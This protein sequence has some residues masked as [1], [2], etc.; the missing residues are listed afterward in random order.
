M[1]NLTVAKSHTGNFYRN[2]TG[3]LYTITV[4]NIG[5]AA[6]DGTTVT[7]ADTLWANITATAISGTGWTCV[8]GTRTC[9]RSDVL[10]AGASYPVITLTVNVGAAANTGT[11]TVT[12]I[13]GGDAT[14]NTAT[15][16]TTVSITASDLTVTKTHAGNFTQ[17]QN[18]AQYTITPRNIGTANAT[19]NITITDTLP[20]G[21][22]YVS[23]TG[24]NWN[25]TAVAQVVTCT[26]TSDVNAGAFGNPITLTVNVSAN[27]TTPLVNVAS[28]SGGNQTYTSN[29]TASDSTI[30]NQLPDLTVTKTHSG[31]FQQGDTGQQYTIT[32]SNIGPG[33]KLAGNTVTV[34]DTLPSDLTATA[35]SGTNWTCVLGTLTC[36]RTD[37]L[38]AG[39]SYPYITLTVDVAGDAEPSL[40]NIASVSL[41]GQS[42]MVTTNNSAYDTVTIFYI[43]TRVTLFD[44]RAYEK[45]GEVI[46]K[47]ETASELDTLGFNLLR[48]D[49]VTGKYEQVNSDLLPAMHR[50]HRG[51]KYT[52]KDTGASPGKTYTYKL[53]EVEIFGRQLTY[54]PFTV[55]VEKNT[56]L[57]KQNTMA[58]GTVLSL[59]SDYTREERD[60]PQLNK[61]LM[62]GKTARKPGKGWE[63]ARGE[64]IKITVTDNGIY[65]IAAQ[66]ISSLMGIS[67]EKVSSLIGRG[68]LSLSNKGKQVAYLP[69]D[70]NAGLY[71]YGTRID[72]LYTKENIYWLDKG[73]G[74]F[75]TVREHAGPEP[76]SVETSFTE[77]MHIEEDAV[78][79]ETLF[80][81]PDADYWFWDQIFASKSYTD[82]PRTFTFQAPGLAIPQTT[83]TLRANLFGA[84]DAGVANDHHVVISLNG[85]SAESWWS[86]LTPHTFT[87][88]FSLNPGENTLTVQGKADKG[89]SSSFVLIDSFDVTYQRLYEA[90]GD[91]LFFS[92]DGNQPITVGGF[93]SPDIM[94]F[95]LT[96]PLRPKLDA[97]TS[98]SA[99][100]GPYTVSLNPVSAKT[101]YLA[102]AED[103][104][105]A[106]PVKAAASSSLSLK[107]NAADYIVIAPAELVST[108]QGL[109]DYRSSQGMKT[110][111]VNLEDIMNE[112]N[113]GI[114]SPEAIRSFLSVAY[115]KWKKAP[116]YV[117]LAG[118]GSMDYKDNLKFGGSLIPSKMVPTDFGLAMSDNYLA[119]VNG[120]HLPEIAIGRL[121]VVNPGELQ[122]V[123]DKIKTYERNLR[124]TTAVLMAD[125]PD[126]GGDFI[127]DSEAVAG[128]FTSA[129][130]VN[131]IYL[132]DPDMAD[133]KRVDLISAINQ[134]AAFFNYVGHAGPDQLSNWGLLSYYPY[135]EYDP[136]ADD[137]SLLTNSKVLPVM[138]A[139]TC[140]IAN[141]SDPYQ[142]VL[143]EALLLKPDGGMAAT[144]SATGLSDDAQ[145]NILNREFYKSVFSVKKAVLGDAVL[146]AL[147]VY[148]KQ[149]TMPFMMD[150]YCI[151][152]DPALRIR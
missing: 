91:R 30:V 65:Y 102:V 88:T 67:L 49:S 106:A 125:T 33:A 133:A 116:R 68:N 118:D 39:S 130:T 120:D 66:N 135:P 111:V 14:L 7:V 80:D 132:T 70:N 104:I 122:T 152:G 147:S 47:W 139:M 6:T 144:W 8:L 110:M 134:G 73:K 137:L 9:T 151:L 13:G 93:S 89:V 22:T 69:A 85:Q 12:V 141:F 18:G 20:T 131:K 55:S 148:N 53:I 123:I 100:S 26:T 76:S 117:V 136:P 96:N 61:V 59:A 87:T 128:L 143:G 40:T 11:N 45:N 52:F 145:A 3:A 38:S 97:A 24:T 124:S 103:G 63:V 43:P 56:V 86:G 138:T 79:W 84:S 34:T 29:D 21:L 10:A 60:H 83:A 126:D 77:T 28:V 150:I 57:S 90:D 72:S 25:C 15:D 82:P 115:L 78:S 23:G 99:E 146:K 129:Y 41:A 74:A 94:V 75:M 121:P 48:L 119:D 54:G 71:F 50:P 81:D 64:R 140:G 35:I 95:D 32:V 4:S 37:A 98:I 127:A 1:R 113:Y 51:G 101:P 142:D 112:F 42:E 27:A 31:S 107:N 114:S 16:P 92:G 58:R 109:A 44:F 36:T 5:G 19:A 62:E 17:G 105:K 46:V 108:A 2:Q 149:G